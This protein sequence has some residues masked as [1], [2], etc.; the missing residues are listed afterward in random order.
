MLM[1]LIGFV[2]CTTI[3]FS[4]GKKL[5]PY[6]NMPAYMI[7]MGKAWPGLMLMSGAAMAGLMYPFKQK[8][9]QLPRDAVIIPVLFH[10]T[11]NLLNNLS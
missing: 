9:W 7:R 6:G 1:H 10:F 3:I 4:D 2:V 5:S 11:M 8:G